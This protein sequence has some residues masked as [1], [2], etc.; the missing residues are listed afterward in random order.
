MKAIKLPPPSQLIYEYPRSDWCINYP[1]PSVMTSSFFIFW[2]ILKPTWNTI[3]MLIFSLYNLISFKPGD[4]FGLA[5]ISSPALS[6][7]Y[8]HLLVSSVIVFVFFIQ[9]FQTFIIPLILPICEG[10]THWLP[11]RRYNVCYWTMFKIQ[12]LLLYK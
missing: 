9:P 5:L 3:K 6:F 1:K 7:I 10:G 12:L 8:Y 4:C 11:N 2:L